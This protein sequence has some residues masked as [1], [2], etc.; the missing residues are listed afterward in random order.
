MSEFGELQVGAAV[1]AALEACGWRAAGTVERELIPAAARGTNLVAVLPPA[2]VHAQ[3]ALAGLAERLAAAPGGQALVLCPAGAVEEWGAAAAPFAAAA[4]L[5]LHASEGLPRSARLLRDGAVDVLVT[6]PAAALAHLARAALK[7]EALRAVVLAW[8]ESFGGDAELTALMA[9]APRDAQRIVITADPGAAGELVERYAR[10]ALAFGLPSADAPS[11]PPAGPV[12]TVSVGWQG[13]AGA[14]GA[15]LD[16]LDPAS[17]TVWAASRATAADALAALPAGGPSVQV[18]TGDAP[19]AALVV[20]FDVPSLPRLEQ[21]LAAGPV[22]LLVPPLAQRYVD[23]LSSAPRPLRLSPALDAAA[24][25]L[26]R[27]RAEVAARV[28]RGV[29]E[30][31]MLALA[32]LLERF[33]AA[34]VA[35]ALYELW[36]EAGGPAA[37]TPAAPVAAGTAATARVWAGI[38]KRDGV[39]PADFVAA[40]TKELRVPRESIGRIELRE[41]YSLLELPAG[42]A[43]R[44]AAQMAGLTIRRKR[45]MARL[46][47]GTAAPP[48]P[49]AGRGRPPRGS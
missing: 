8:P 46:D 21:L 19:P 38:G 42:E 2:A 23:G 31:G 16:L 47:R 28:E 25:A 3:P 14:L 41:G 5:R 48:R 40:L 18:V 12:R 30:H 24:D 1:A 43:E 10:R 26:V 33:D 9:D 27:R 49:G 37:P 22:V 4:G 44:I 6:T 13:R 35:A 32:P 45:V 7:V 11:P 36:Q 34:R 15:L 39:T 17:V 29:P 20:A